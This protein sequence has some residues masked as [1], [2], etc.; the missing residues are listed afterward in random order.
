MY[1]QG[2]FDSFWEK[3]IILK[4]KKCQ[5]NK[6]YSYCFKNFK[7][8]INYLIHPSLPLGS[9]MVDILYGCIL[10]KTIVIFISCDCMICDKKLLE[11]F[12][13]F[14]Y[15]YENLVCRYNSTSR[16]LTKKG[17]SHPRCYGDV[18]RKKTCTFFQR[19]CY[20]DALLFKLFI[21]K[22]YCLSK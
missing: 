4:N 12:S 2:R 16:N 19:Y 18:L 13:H 22:K 20:G 3:N 10:F 1:Q 21:Q 7:T 6:Y 11:K 15:Q 5:L 17:I 8:Y 9:S 14:Y